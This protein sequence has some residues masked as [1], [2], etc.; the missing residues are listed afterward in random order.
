MNCLESKGAWLAA[1]ILWLL[2]ITILPLIWLFATPEQINAYFNNDGFSP[3]ESATIGLFWLQIALFWLLPPMSPQPRRAFWLA[4]F[5]LLTFF[6][7][8]R[9]LDWHKL[10]VSVSNLPGATHGTP[11]KMRFI[12]NSHNPF[13]D[14]LIVLFCFILVLGLCGLTL[15]YFLPRL[16]RGL[17]ALHPVCWSLGFLGGTLMLSQFADRLPAILRNKFDV[18][19]S[20]NLRALFIALEEGMELLLPLFVILA[21]L[22]AYFIYNNAPRKTLPLERF[23]TM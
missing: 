5:S 3:V 22:Q 18:Q 7:I 16:L 12:T 1:P 10:L 14:R 11:F 21:V 20:E 6:A 13:A 2:A 23:K 9:E 19:L 15:A 4:D 8:C 17:W